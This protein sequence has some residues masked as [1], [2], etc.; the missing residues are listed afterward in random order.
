MPNLSGSEKLALYLE[1]E[2]A[3]EEAE[4]WN[5]QQQAVSG[6]TICAWCH[7]HPGRHQ[8]ETI[9]AHGTS[10]ICDCCLKKIWEETLQNVTKGLADLEVRCPN[11]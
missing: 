5:A 4:D 9:L 2:A 8:F 3:R 10:L 6:S 1:G 11:V 7:K